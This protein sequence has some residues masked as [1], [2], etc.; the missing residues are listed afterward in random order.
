MKR[1]INYLD[2][3]QDHNKLSKTQLYFAS[4]GILLF[5]TLALTLPNYLLKHQQILKGQAQTALALP[6]PPPPPGVT[7]PPSPE[8][9]TATPIPPTNTQVPP[10]PTNTPVPTSTPVPP[11]PTPVIDT[12]NPSVNI[13]FPANGST[14]KRKTNITVQASASDNKAVTKVEFRRNSTL[15]CS[16]T[17][18]PYSC[19][20]FTDNGNNS[21]VTY[22]AR[23]FDAAGNTA[24][25]NISVKT[26]R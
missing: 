12:I 3:F 10:A 19:S 4:F 15:I 8:S 13:T 23:A 18:S 17:T 24:N 21:T 6:P 7:N 1:F 9:P 22:S 5:L 14:V 11:T 2:R 16:D 26:G 20:M 25:H